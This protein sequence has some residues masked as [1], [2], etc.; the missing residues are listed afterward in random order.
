MHPCIRAITLLIINFTIDS[1]TQI[2]QYET[3]A[4]VWIYGISI[5]PYVFSC[6]MVVKSDFFVYSFLEHSSDEKKKGL[7]FFLTL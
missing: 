2:F 7:H 1:A 3:S 4:M 5:C 6:K